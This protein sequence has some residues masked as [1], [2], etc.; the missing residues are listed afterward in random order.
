MK[1]S[2]WRGQGVEY[3]D[4]SEVACR[5]HNWTVVM[6]EDRPGTTHVQEMHI[7]ADCHV[8]RCVAQDESGRCVLAVHHRWIHRYPDLTSEAV[9]GYLKR[10]SDKAETD[11]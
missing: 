9:G 3:G 1:L 10:P 2:D 11:A 8:R 4:P 5:P 7:C 6:L